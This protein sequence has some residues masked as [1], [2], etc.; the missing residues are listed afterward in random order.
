MKRNA[1]NLPSWTDLT[2]PTISD[3]CANA[4]WQKLHRKGFSPVWV[5]KEQKID[6]KP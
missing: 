2:W 5:L 3:R 4:F 1:K 6:N